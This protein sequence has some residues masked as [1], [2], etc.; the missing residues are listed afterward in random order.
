MA[1]AISKWL[2]WLNKWPNGAQAKLVLI[3]IPFNFN[4]DEQYE[5]IMMEDNICDLILDVANW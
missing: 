1:W 2:K 4:H 3:G 5:A